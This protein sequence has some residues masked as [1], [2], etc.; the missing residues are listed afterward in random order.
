[1]IR[2]QTIYSPGLNSIK[3]QKFCPGTQTRSRDKLPS[4]SLGIPKTLSLSP[5][6]VDQPAT[7]P[8]LQ[9]SPGD[10]QGWLRSKKPQSRATP[11]EP[12]GD[13]IASY[14]GIAGDPKEA[15]RMP[16]RDIIQR[17]LALVNQRRRRSN[18]LESLQSR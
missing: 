11:R 2:E 13:F 5:V 17:L 12:I 14:S 9:I 10:T 7:E 3:G 15:H 4:L 6:L 8:L 1:M 16:I 18:S